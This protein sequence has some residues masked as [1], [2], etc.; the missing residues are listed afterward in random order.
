[1]VASFVSDERDE[2]G[3]SV[4]GV[5]FLGERDLAR[6]TPRR[7]GLLQTFVYPHGASSLVRA[8]ASVLT[9]SSG[10][11]RVSPTGKFNEV[12]RVEWTADVSWRTRKADRARRRESNASFALAPPIAGPPTGDGATQHIECRGGWRLSVPQVRRF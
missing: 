5:R 12:Y 6:F 8:R 7:S 10:L 3:H 9:D 2:L 4:V 11:P 1:M